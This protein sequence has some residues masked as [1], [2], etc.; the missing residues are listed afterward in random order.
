MG[1]VHRVVPGNDLMKHTRDYAQVLCQNRFDR[2]SEMK[3]RINAIAKTGMP[4]VN[5][6]TEV[7]Q[8]TRLSF[9]FVSIGGTCHAGWNSWPTPPLPR[10][11][12][13]ACAPL[14]RGNTVGLGR[15][16]PCACP[17]GFH[18]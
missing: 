17:V 8:R 10:R 3:A 4:E 6:M 7:P 9:L 15:H 5:A 2:F 11:A 14:F 13:P 1:L 16:P 18:N 12:T